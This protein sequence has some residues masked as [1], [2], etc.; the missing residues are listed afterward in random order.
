MATSDLPCVTVDG[1][2]TIGIHNGVAR[3]LFVRMS[4][5]GKALPALELLIP[6]SQA[7]HIVKGLAGIR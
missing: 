6:V 1:I 2:Q 5:E 4:A 7:V 3:V